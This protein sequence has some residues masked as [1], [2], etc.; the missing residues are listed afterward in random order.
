MFNK[1]ANNNN[2]IVSIEGNIGS[3]KSTLLEKLK[4]HFYNNNK[5]L[6]LKEPVDDWSTIRDLNNKT[7]LELFYEDQTKHAFA[8]QM[9]AYISRLAI[10]KETLQK[11][12]NCII[13][14][15][16]SLY[17]DKMVFAKMLFDNNNISL[18]NYSI[19]LKWFNTFVDSFSVDKIVYVKTDPTICY[20]R[21][22][23]RSRTGESNI[24][25]YYLQKCHNYHE[26]MLD[27]NTDKCVC[28]N[29]IIVDGNADIYDSP[30]Q[31]VQ[32][33]LDIETFI[34]KTD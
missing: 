24:E 13:I 12:S 34:Y 4:L 21:I 15:E 31:L 26:S 2:I 33:I 20:S 10:L 17:T 7:I 25:L 19:Y 22:Q 11:N 16:R 8:F 29:Q 18:E 27:V 30:N 1:S 6:F 32:W 9:M 5:I 28:K 14:T 3:G 23:K